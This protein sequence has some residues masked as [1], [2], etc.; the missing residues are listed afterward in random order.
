MFNIKLPG[1]STDYRTV[2]LTKNKVE[3]NGACKLLVMINDVTDSVRREQDKLK[4]GRER[5]STFDV[6]G[7]LDYGLVRHCEAVKKL[8][9]HLDGVKLKNL[10][11]S[12][13]RT[14]LDLVLNFCQFADL[15]N[16]QNDTFQ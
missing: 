9:K 11:L 4:K 8:C 1:T 13:K 7:R 12:V 15:V 5:Q 14:T 3:V 10:G 2:K 6:Q 16:I